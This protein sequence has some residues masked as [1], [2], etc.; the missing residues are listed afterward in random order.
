MRVRTENRCYGANE[1]EQFCEDQGIAVL[2]ADLPP[3]LPAFFLNKAIIIQQG[4]SP[5]QTVR[6]AWHELGHW[7]CH[8]GS[9]EFWR[10]RPLGHLIMSKMERQAS[11]FAERFPLW[12]GD[13]Y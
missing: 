2:Y 8:V 13:G 1:W 11:D 6:L 3:S 10:T 12:G 9:Q 7:V 5:Q 4:L